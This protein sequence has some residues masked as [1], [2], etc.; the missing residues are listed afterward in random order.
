MS[1]LQ[2]RPIT[3]LSE[4]RHS[5]TWRGLTGITINGT[6]NDRKTNQRE[7]RRQNALTTRSTELGPVTSLKDQAETSDADGPSHR[8]DSPNDQSIEGVPADDVFLAKWK[9]VEMFKVR[10]ANA[11]PSLAQS[12]VSPAQI[13]LSF[14]QTTILLASLDVGWGLPLFILAEAAGEAEH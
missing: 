1:P 8:S 12:S 4:L 3:V 5:F 11:L 13:V 6:L 2:R 10:K 14:I 7:L 9:A